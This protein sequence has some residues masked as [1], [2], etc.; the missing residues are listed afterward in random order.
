MS[1]MDKAIQKLI[2]AIRIE[3]PVPS[4]HHHVMRKHRKEW[5]TL[6]NAIDKIVSEHQKTY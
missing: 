3:G 6:W 5:P 2:D 1:E 4:Y